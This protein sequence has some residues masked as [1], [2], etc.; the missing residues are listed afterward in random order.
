MI[1]LKKIIKFAVITALSFGAISLPAITTQAKT[2]PIPASLRGKWRSKDPYTHK[3]NYKTI[4]KYTIVEKYAGYGKAYWTIKPTK[5]K[6][7]QRLYIGRLKNGYYKL[8][9]QNSSLGDTIKRIK[10]K[11]HR[12]TLRCYT[13]NMDHYT[14]IGKA[15]YWYHY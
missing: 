1:N 2:K 11:K 3:Y 9:T 5:S 6:K 15:S 4:G 13:S 12:A 8:E 14:R 10:S 7:Y